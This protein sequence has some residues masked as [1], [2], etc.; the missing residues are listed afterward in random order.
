MAVNIAG[1]QFDFGLRRGWEAFPCPVSRNLR[2]ASNQRSAFEL[3]A[4]SVGV[5][6][7]VIVV[8]EVV[9]YEQRAA[10]STSRIRPRPLEKAIS[11][12]KITCI[13]PIEAVRSAQWVGAH[14]GIG[15][16]PIIARGPGLFEILKPARG[17]RAMHHFA[18]ID[19][20]TQIRAHRA[21]QTRASRVIPNQLHR[22]LPTP[23]LPRPNRRDGFG[24]STATVGPIQ[25][26]RLSNRTLI[27]NP[28][29]PPGL[30]TR[31]IDRRGQYAHQQRNYRDHHQQFDEGK[32]PAPSF[33]LDQDVPIADYRP[34]P[35]S[36][37]LSGLMMLLS[38]LLL[39]LY[40]HRAPSSRTFRLTAH[41]SLLS[42]AG[43]S[44]CAARIRP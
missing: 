23:I 4:A 37:I 20:R 6:A 36:R 26:R 11:A 14:W 32:P 22:L 12:F 34:L 24:E 7:F 42:A 35:P 3:L 25:I 28:K 5:R 9:A 15:I 13:A 33:P 43:F 29:H 38:I 17:T 21:V 18:P 2:S 16:V 30:P 44:R 40:L 10:P 19:I 27:A 1:V 39:T 8:A 41:N 31:L